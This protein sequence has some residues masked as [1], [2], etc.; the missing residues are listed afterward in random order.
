MKSLSNSNLDATIID[1][2]VHMQRAID[3]AENVWT[4]TPNPR[5]G[6]VL[7]K[8][9]E[10]VGEG[11]HSAAGQA[12]AEIAALHHAGE[13]ASAA[14]AFVSLEPCAHTGRTGP[15]SEALIHAGVARVV[16]ATLDP[17]P[18]VAGKGVWQLEQAGIEVSLLVDFDRQA[19]AVNRGYF[20]RR[21]QGLPYVSLKLAMSL[22]GRTA[23]ANGESKWI[24]SAAARS[25]V[26]RLRASVSAVITGINTVLTDD[27]SLNVRREDL[28]E[29]YDVFQ[30]KSGGLNRQP[31]RVILDSQLRTPGTARIVTSEGEVKIYTRD[32]RLAEKNLASNVEIVGVAS[33]AGGVN[34]RSVLESLASDF[35]CNDV[36]IEAGPT[37]SGAFITAGL[38]DELV[39]YIAPKILGSDAKPLLQLTGLQAL[40]DS[41]EFTIDELARVGDD[42]RVTLKQKRDYGKE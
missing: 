5:V 11:W 33:S 29:N 37:L 4:T 16:I 7:A 39:V 15:C 40:A 6:C 19:R 28:A 35:A 2:P 34:L 3:L 8:D 17:N 31:L 41:I 14:T 23:L 25:D 21:E 30:A 24:T 27:P 36:L 20:Q 12:H 26:Q 22:D 9:G 18:E 32:A 13:K 42:I 38:V 10:V 1:W